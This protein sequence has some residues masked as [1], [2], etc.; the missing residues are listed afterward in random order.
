MRTI[1]AKKCKRPHHWAQDKILRKLEYRSIKAP[2]VY[3]EP[4]RYL[5]PPRQLEMEAIRDLVLLDLNTVPRG[6]W[7][8]A[9]G[10]LTRGERPVINDP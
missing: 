4:H 2:L 9:R 1:A 10:R 8:E 6:E 3:A 7:R 5:G